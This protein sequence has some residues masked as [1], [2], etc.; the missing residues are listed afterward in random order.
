M[1]RKNRRKYAQIVIILVLF[2]VLNG[3][4]GA[5]DKKTGGQK[6]LQKATQTDFKEEALV[7][8]ELHSQEPEAVYDSD[9]PVFIRV[10]LYSPRS[11]A[12]LNH[13]RYKTKNAKAIDLPEIKVEN[14]DKFWWQ[15][16]KFTY[17]S[18][19]GTKGEIEFQHSFSTQEIMPDI[20]QGE[21]GSLETIIHENSF[22]KPGKYIIKAFWQSKKFGRIVSE[23]LPI[24]LEK[25]HLTSVDRDLLR[26]K[27]LLATNK[28]DDAAVLIKKLA[29][30]HPE[31]YTIKYYLAGVYEKNNNLKEALIQ[32]QHALTLFPEEKPG[33]PWEPPVGLEIK[34]RSLLKKLGK[35]KK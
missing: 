14:S 34:I 32:Y 8:L 6:I 15:M 26:V 23:D 5:E 13:N 11:F 21:V 22:G 2:L 35:I 24:S 33:E 7:A 16:L 18:A 12:L 27:A 10:E 19:D 1:K 20:G 25:G 17:T 31:S 28:N 9:A 30:D 29:E 4:G 3:C